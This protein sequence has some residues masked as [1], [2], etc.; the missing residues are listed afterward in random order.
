M[1]NPTSILRN[2]VEDISRFLSTN[3]DKNFKIGDYAYFIG[4]STVLHAVQ[5]CMGKGQ[6]LSWRP[7]DLD[8]YLSIDASS[9]IKLKDTLSDVKKIKIESSEEYLTIENSMSFKVNTYTLREPIN[10]IYKKDFENIGR[11]AMKDKIFRMVDI[12]N[13]AIIY[14]PVENEIYSS[15]LAR[16]N[17]MNRTQCINPFFMERFK[18]FKR[19][20]GLEKLSEGEPFG[21]NG[22]LRRLA[23]MADATFKRINKYKLRN[24][25][26]TDRDIEDF[27]TLKE[28]VKYLGG[29]HSNNG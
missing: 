3:T 18:R 29:T 21:D 5:E 9:F 7:N 4:G 25:E 28:F 27:R 15:E 6:K 17:I 24:L 8:V 11:G 22:E 14:D 12:A 1:A 10:F 16:E 19:D 20:L 26:P 13:L 2:K 23:T